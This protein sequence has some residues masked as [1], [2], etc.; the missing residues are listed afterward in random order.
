MMNNSEGDINT[1]KHDCYVVGCKGKCTKKEIQ[2]E[3]NI[4]TIDGV[5]YVCGNVDDLDYIFGILT[6][7]E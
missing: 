7:D 1:C 4:E 2:L 5:E 6:G 3:L